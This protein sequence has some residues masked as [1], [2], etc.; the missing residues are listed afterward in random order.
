M[1]T[2]DRDNPQV[3]SGADR[4]P[5]ETDVY[6]CVIESCKY[7]Q[8]IFPEDDGTLPMK[9]VIVWKEEESGNYLWERYN[10]FYGSTKSGAPSKWK[11]FL[12]GLDAQGLLPGGQFDPEAALPG[13]RQRLSVQKYIKSKGANAGQPGNKVTGVLPMKKAAPKEDE[14][15]Y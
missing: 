14:L 13:I 11:A 4:E 5:L 6:E 10:P 1:P 8:S 3:S 7:E 15:A 12:D 2:I 9:Y